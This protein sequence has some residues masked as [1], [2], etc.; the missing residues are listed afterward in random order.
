MRWLLLVLAVAFSP[1]DQAA[2][3]AHLRALLA[4]VGGEDYIARLQAE[5]EILRRGPA[6]IPE[7]ERAIVEARRTRRA[8]NERRYAAILE[9]LV[10]LRH[11]PMDVGHKW[12]YGTGGADVVFE[13][14]G[15]K[16]LRGVDCFVVERRGEGEKLDLGLRISRRGVRLYMAGDHEFVPPFGEIVFPIRVG[17]AWNWRGTIGGHEFRIKSTVG[18]RQEVVTPMGTFTAFK[19]TEEATLAPAPGTPSRSGWTDL[20]LADGIGVVKL[21]GKGIDLHNGTYREFSWRLKSFS[22]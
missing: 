16:R 8:G 5:N 22:R 21:E 1:Q 9:L 3:A 2:E 10:S 6:A 19:I 20:W 14:R 18:R 7:V 17:G 12:V 13:A 4:R 11:F 15:R